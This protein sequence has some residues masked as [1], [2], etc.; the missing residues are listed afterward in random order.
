MTKVLAMILAG[1]RGE[2]MGILSYLRAKPIL[3]FAGKFRVIDFVLTNCVRSGIGDI[4]VLT[5]YQRSSIES[6]L[7]QW[8]FMNGNHSNFHVL[9][10]KV[11]SYT[12]TADAVYQNIDY[13]QRQSA[14]S[15]LIL[16][17]DHIYKMDYSKMLAF[18]QKVEADVTVG[19]VSVPIEQAHRFGIVKTRNEGR[20]VDF[21]EKPRIPGSNLV[22]MG[23]Y[24]FNKQ[25]LLERLAED[26]AD[27][28]SPHD[29]GHAIIPKMVSRDKV[30]AYKFNEYWQD[31]GTVEAY[32][33]ANMELTRQVPSLSLNT[34]WSILTQDDG[35][36][37]PPKISGQGSVKDSL[38]SPGCVIKG[39]VHDS[40]LSPGVRVE[41]KAV[42]RNSIIM[43]ETVIG[44]HSVVDRSILDEGVKVGEFC[45]VGLRTS[46][47][48]SD[49]GIT[50]VG[51]AVTIPSHTAICSSCRVLPDVGPGDFVKHVVHAGT[52]VSQHLAQLA[53]AGAVADQTFRREIVG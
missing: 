45:Y 17:A 19:V 53:S 31:I 36:L 43:A 40:I 6:Y 4:A 8:Q 34:Q 29:F 49:V 28:S 32:Y 42:V 33:R 37:P 39:E 9:E 27:L 46:R 14:N 22:S 51:K 10:P 26:A 20:I 16:A 2:R 11:S 13:L 35:S 5:D 52:V 3:S 12:G 23:I 44:E 50:V 30:F 18:H 21:V 1:G 41:E 24:I 7:S 15:I 47:V 48:P 25:T 38:I